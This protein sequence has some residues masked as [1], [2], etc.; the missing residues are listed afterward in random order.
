[1]KASKIEFRLRVVFMMLIVSLGFSAPWIEAWKIGSR[2]SLLEWL[3][4]ELS[5]LGLL[6]FSVATPAVIVLASLF[7]ALG[8]F[9][10]VWGTAYLGPVTVNSTQMHACTVLADG[11][12][13][14]VRNPLYLGSWFMFLTIAFLMPATGALVAMLGLTLFLFRLI[15]GEEAFL[16]AQIGPPYQDYLRSTPRILPRLRSNLPPGTRTPHWVRSIFAELASIGVFVTM[17]GLSWTYN[18]WLMV[19]GII[20]SFGISLIGRAL[21][22]GAS[23]APASPQ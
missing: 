19:Q 16:T 6:T 14:Y 3:A 23:K 12:Y 18:H 15:L 21:T 11:P 1:M 8:A 13:R 2:I 7:A 20:V 4:L 9:M 5:R 17:A 10:R 22:I